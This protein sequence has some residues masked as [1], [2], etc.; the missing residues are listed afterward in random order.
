MAEAGESLKR[1][2]DLKDIY[3]GKEWEEVSL[4]ASDLTNVVI[5]MGRERRECAPVVND[6]DIKQLIE[7]NSKP[8]DPIIY[9]DGSVRRGEQS[10]WGFVVFIE[11]TRVHKS[12]RGTARTTSSMRMEIEAI[13]KALCWLREDR[14]ETTHLVVVTDSQSILRKIEKRLLR[15]E[16]IEAIEQT[17]LRAIAWIFCPGHSGVQGN[18][19][20]DKLAG[21]ASAGADIPFDKAEI[22]KILERS[23]RDEV[24]KEMEDHHAIT[25]MQEMGFGR[26]EGRRSRLCGRE[27]RLYNQTATGTISLDTLRRKLMRGTEHLWTCPVCCEVDSQDK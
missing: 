14:A 4:E 26:G 5:T 6:T 25:R 2:C 27:R 7:E 1:V 8:G 23:L 11:N 13:T 20:A 15:S 17:S 19:E 10:G 3:T 18:E 22:L 9:T 16:W 24:E 12:S 21:T